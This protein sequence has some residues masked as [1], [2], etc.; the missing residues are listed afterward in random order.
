MG[1]REKLLDGA[2]TCL[3]QKGYARTTARDIATTAGVSLAAIGYHFGTTEALLSAALFQAMGR[4]AEQL[5]QALVDDG[6]KGL[7]PV[8]RRAAVW[9]RVIDSVRADPA[10][11][12]VQF[13]LVTEIQR[14]PEL[15]EQLAGAQVAAR[16]GLAELF[17]GIDPAAEPD[18][19]HRV[20]ALYQAL[21]TGVVAQHL[22]DPT[23]APGA[24]ELARGLP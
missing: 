7:P 17:E 18:R 19:A 10:L 2:L 23:H 4:W 14:R 12:A 5:E 13:E 24:A 3:L 9:R 21:L 11:W 20:G 6:D 1:N 15:R 8:E 22:V 16:E